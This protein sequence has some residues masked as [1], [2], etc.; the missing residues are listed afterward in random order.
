V[1]ATDENGMVRTTV[2]LPVEVRDWIAE[3]GK[4]EQRSYDAQAR[5]LLIELHKEDTDAAAS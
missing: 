5:F 1:N 4:A 2:S 3:Q